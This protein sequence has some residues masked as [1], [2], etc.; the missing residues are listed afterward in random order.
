M[1][2][3]LSSNLRSTSTPRSTSRSNSSGNRNST[4]AGSLSRTMNHNTTSIG[5]SSWA[6]SSRSS[7]ASSTA[8]S[9]SRYDDFEASDRDELGEGY[10][11]IEIESKGSN[12]KINMSNTLSNTAK[13]SLKQ[14]DMGT[15]TA[16]SATTTNTTTTS[17]ANRTEEILPNGSKIVR[18]KN[19]TEKQ[20]DPKG[21]STVRFLNGDTKSVDVTAGTVVYYYRE[22]DT[23][24]TTF[25]DG[26]E[27]YE[28]PNKQV[29]GCYNI[30]IFSI[31]YIPIV[32]DCFL[33]KQYYICNRVLD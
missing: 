15:T 20:I 32:L 16:L 7:V 12:T 33:F 19:G 2:N 3:R 6:R 27:V 5:R 24:H 17:E 11:G 13:P 31:E 10:S 30:C 22:A 8:G 1:F 9:A 26:L 28:F 29:I 18:Y 21:N 4:G 14:E 25:Q 23:T